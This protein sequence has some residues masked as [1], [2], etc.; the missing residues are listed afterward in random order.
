MT[1]EETEMAKGIAEVIDN[2]AKT[3]EKLV[4]RSEDLEIWLQRVVR[5][6]EAGHVALLRLLIAMVGELC[7]VAGATQDERERIV[8]VLSVLHDAEVTNVHF[9]D[10]AA[11]NRF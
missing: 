10:I 6:Q 8:H 9:A 1:P 3:L 5:V 2:H 11:T 4:Q 7:N